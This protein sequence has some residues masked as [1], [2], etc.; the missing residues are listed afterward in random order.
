MKMIKSIIII[1]SLILAACGEDNNSGA[2]AI[3]VEEEDHF[4]ANVMYPDGVIRKSNRL[5]CSDGCKIHIWVNDPSI[6]FRECL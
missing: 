3:C 6:N 1:F 4:L 5:V 2:D